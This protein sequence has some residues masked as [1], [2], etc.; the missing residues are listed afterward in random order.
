[1]AMPT[2]PLRPLAVALAAAVIPAGAAH[3]AETTVTVT[4]GRT[5]SFDSGW[6]CTVR[7]P[8][9]TPAASD[10]GSFFLSVNTTPYRP[11][12]DPYSADSWRQWCSGGLVAGYSS[13]ADRGFIAFGSVPGCI[14]RPSL[15]ST[16]ARMRGTAATTMSV[17]YNAR[18][19][20]LT[21][22]AGAVR[23]VIPAVHEYMAELG[24]DD[25]SEVSIDDVRVVMD[26]AAVVAV[27]G[28]SFAAAQ[29]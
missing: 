26:G 25:I 19:D 11:W 8:S 16:I 2:N 1:M 28:V 17:S 9:A 6:T 23:K 7:L 20:R 4:V 14:A 12:C 24:L 22:T 3:A 29:P 21:I 27:D 5:V 18:K 13:S 15:R 10:G